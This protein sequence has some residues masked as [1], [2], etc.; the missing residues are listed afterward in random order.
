M[1]AY[2][3]TP[4][5]ALEREAEVLPLELYTRIIALRRA[6]KI[7][8][9]LVEDEIAEAL[10]RLWK[11]TSGKDDRGSCPRPPGARERIRK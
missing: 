5:A 7:A 2:K 9:H 3:R 1:G 6:E 11:L 8:T 10:D 4:I